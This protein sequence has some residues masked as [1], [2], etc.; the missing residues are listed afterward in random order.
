M[1]STAPLTSSSV[2]L[3]LPPRAGMDPLEPLKPSNAWLYKVS[4]PWAIRGPQSALSPGLGAPATPAAW[5]MAQVLL[6]TALPASAVAAGA[7]LAAGASEAAAV[8][9]EAGCAAGA[10]AAAGAGGAAGACAGFFS[11]QAV[12]NRAKVASA[13]T[14]DVFFMVV[15]RSE[16]WE[17]DC[18]KALCP[19]QLLFRIEQNRAASRSADRQDRG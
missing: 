12:R 11:P 3:G 18:C 8:G 1:W 10:G 14:E 13:M 16:S 5:H 15:R 9:A 19:D 7:A 2:N 4:L 6:K 17:M